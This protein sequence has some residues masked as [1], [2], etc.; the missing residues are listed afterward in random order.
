[1][2]YPYLA[3]QE[4]PFPGLPIV[5]INRKTGSQTG[6]FD[7]M[8]DTGAD[9][10][11]VPVQVLRSIGATMPRRT[12]RLRSLWGEYRQVQVILVDMDI[13]GERLAAVEVVADDRGEDIL[14]GR[15]VLNKLIL[16]L[17]GPNKQTDLLKRRPRRV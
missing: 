14:L 7:V 13:A 4:T 2:P 12:A 16:L 8:I 17:D 1:M 6:V 3:G 10:T 9:A 15:N 5:I 11:L